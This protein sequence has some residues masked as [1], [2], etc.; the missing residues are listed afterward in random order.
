MRILVVV[1]AV[2]TAGC[3]SGPRPKLADVDEPKPAVPQP[4]D[5]VATNTAEA[6]W[7]A[8]L[9]YYAGAVAATSAIAASGA[10]HD[11]H[12]QLGHNPD[13]QGWGR[14]AN[15][16]GYVVPAIT[17]PAIW[18]VGRSLHDRRVI[19][20][21]SAAIQ[22]VLVTLATTGALKVATGRP[23]PAA[24]DGLDPTRD[25][26]FQPFQHGI[27]AWPSGH[28]AATISI[29]AALW[30]YSPRQWWIAAIGYPLALGM[31]FGMVNRDSHWTSDIVAG[32]LI[33]H[34]IGFSI[35]RSFREHMRGERPRDSFVVGPM[36]GAG[37]PGLAIT[38]A[39]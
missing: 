19:G 14:V 34:A 10:D 2:C 11:V 8:N 32:A 16:A 13:L 36:V 7:G 33:G 31:G 5:H 37:A 29:A 20:A 3:A 12:Q 24:D 38:G 39:W 26:E 21:G 23:Y 4:W 25:R 22:S 35:G 27:G 28:T 15:I 30:G 9:L 17:P 1:V 6:F 18:L